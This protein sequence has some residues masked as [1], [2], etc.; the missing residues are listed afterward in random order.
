MERFTALKDCQN[1]RLKSTLN[2]ETKR[3]SM[4]PQNVDL[5]ISLTTKVSV[6]V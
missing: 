1:S 4:E 3:S 2:K 6:S 5:V